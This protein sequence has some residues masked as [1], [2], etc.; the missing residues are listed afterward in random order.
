MTAL[1]KER[2]ALCLMAVSS[3]EVGG[4][5]QPYAGVAITVSIM[6]WHAWSIVA[7]VGDRGIQGV[8]EVRQGRVERRF[9]AIEVQPVAGLAEMTMAATFIP[10][11]EI[12]PQVAV[13][14]ID[15][16]LDQPAR[17]LE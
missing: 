13:R 4:F 15:L 2:I 6:L 14:E 16:A 12:A 3:Q 7:N 5:M 1:T 17:V 8:Q 9:A 11:L 10:G